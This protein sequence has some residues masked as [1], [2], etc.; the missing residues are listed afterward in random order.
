MRALGRLTAAAGHPVPIPTIARET[1]A[2]AETGGG[3]PPALLIYGLPVA[4]LV[5]AAAIAGRRGRA[6][7]ATS[8]RDS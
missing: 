5:V 7:D 3:N 1:V 4:L 8:G 6:R 2:R